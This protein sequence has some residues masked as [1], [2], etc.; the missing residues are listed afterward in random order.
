MLDASG[1]LQHNHDGSLTL[2]SSYFQHQFIKLYVATCKH[3][4]LVSHMEAE[5][6][7]HM[8]TCQ[9]CGVDGE[10]QLV[11]GEHKLGTVSQI[12]STLS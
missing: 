7:C 9:Y 4:Y 5:C 2:C 12:S 3:Q 1:K 11:E 8:V 6:P 10:Y